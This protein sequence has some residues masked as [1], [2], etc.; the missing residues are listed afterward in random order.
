MKIFDVDAVP[1]VVLPRHYD[2]YAQEL[3]GPETG[4]PDI[5]VLYC[6]VEPNGGAEMHDHDRSEH[7]FLVL[8]G[9]L[10]VDDGE[11]KHVVSAGQAMV[12]EPGEPHQVTGTGGE[13]DCTYVV[14]TIPPAWTK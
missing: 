1:K 4:N 5:S 6:Q 13:V 11:Q 14:I 8:D 9:E 12:I 10:Q 7:I 2:C 3:R